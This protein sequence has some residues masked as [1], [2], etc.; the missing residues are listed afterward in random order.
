MREGPRAL[1]A[2]KVFMEN[3]MAWFGQGLQTPGSVP[4]VGFKLLIAFAVLWALMK[5]WENIN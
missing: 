2:R 5:I 3:F 4:Y 1:E